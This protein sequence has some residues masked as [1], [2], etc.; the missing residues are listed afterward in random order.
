MII[1]LH[2]II[3]FHV[4]LSNTNNFQ[5]SIRPIDGTLI[6]TPTSDQSRHGSNEKEYFTLPKD[7][8]LEPHS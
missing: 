2:T 5:T 6:V 7:S 4:F 3:W 8:E 1:S